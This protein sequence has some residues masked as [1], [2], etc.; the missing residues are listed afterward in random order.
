MKTIYI[1]RHGDYDNPN[2]IIPFRSNDVH[3]SEKGKLQIT[4]A[5]NYLK[6]KNIQALYS[7]PVVRC[8]ESAQIASEILNLKINTDERLIEVGS[9]FSNY[10]Y[11][12]YLKVMEDIEL[13][14]YKNDF[15]K[16]NGGETLSSIYE[17]LKSFRSEVLKNPEDNILVVSHGDPIMAFICNERRIQFENGWPDTYI[18]KGGIVKLEYDGNK[19][20]AFEKVNY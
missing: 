5:A 15:H 16:A 9:P 12:E 3:L 13:N 14:V 10:K 18:P 20:I 17:R 8:Q 4:E 6:D 11:A 1:L 2:E 7:S 19:L